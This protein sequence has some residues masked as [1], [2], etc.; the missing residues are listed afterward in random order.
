[1]IE[2]IFWRAFTRDALPLAL[3]GFPEP[4]SFSSRE[5]LDPSNV[6]AD[7]V[8]VAYRTSPI[9][10]SY[11]PPALLVLDDSTAA[12]LFSWLNVYEPQTSPLS[13]FARII[14]SSDFQ[15]LY[16]PQLTIVEE[17]RR[18]D[19]WASL[20]LGEILAEGDAGTDLN[21][22]PISR[23]GSCLATAMGRA[24]MIYPA[25]SASSLCGNR[26]SMLEGDPRFSKRR[27]SVQELSLGWEIIGG[28]RESVGSAADA[29]NQVVEGVALYS[30]N[31]LNVTK[32]VADLSDYPGLH[33]DS[34]EE[35]VVTFNRMVSEVLHSSADP[36]SKYVLSALLGAAAFLVGRGT[37]HAFLLHKYGKQFPSSYA[38]FGAV[39]ALAGPATWDAHWSKSTK[40][41]ERGI[42]MSFDWADP[43][44]VDLC[45]SEFAWMADS[46]H[47]GAEAFSAMPRLSPK[48]LSIEIIPGVACQFRLTSTPARNAA[49]ETPSGAHSLDPELQSILLQL[50]SLGA[51]ARGF[52]DSF[53]KSSAPM[54]QPLDLS[55][56]APYKNA[57]PKK[58]KR[59]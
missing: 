51:K 29:A 13:Q 44:T 43:P 41:I 6:P 28:A 7:C 56:E 52:V 48:E 34:V 2:K 22:I 54:Q 46:F 26:L 35:R 38:W 55:E 33:S 30:R 31:T 32:S 36:K 49:A 27:V 37:S 47:G 18:S 24:A 42:R 40:L 3:F 12:E 9:R 11:S 17:N 59:L 50:T 25:H 23:A 1:M 19:R 58:G 21:A 5:L 57:R 53:P 8:A 10:N 45:W 4:I 20:A 14:G 16:R 39:A 15:L